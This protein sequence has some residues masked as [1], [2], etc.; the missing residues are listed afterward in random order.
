MDTQEKLNA[1][2]EKTYDAQRGY[3]NA[4]EMAKDPNVKNWLAHQG[5]RR[6]EYA[7]AITGEMKGMNKEPELDGSMTG[8]LHRSWTNI[9]AALSSEKD[10][11]VLEECIRGEKAAVEEYEDVLNDAS[12]LPPTVVSI[13]Q[14]Q[15]DE[16][17]AT[18]NSIKRI[19]DIVENSND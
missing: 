14:A 12:H 1:L 15:K 8:D 19:E 10:E 11:I 7:A 3:A 5:A 6:T 4:A 16:I 18:I 2:L 9:K 17:S 13:L